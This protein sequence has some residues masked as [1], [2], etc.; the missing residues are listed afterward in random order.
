VLRR[1]TWLDLPFRYPPARL[2]L[3]GLK[4]SLNF[5]LRD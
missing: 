4:R 5:L 3:G 1:G 2:S